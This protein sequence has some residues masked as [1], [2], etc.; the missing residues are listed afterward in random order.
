M[1]LDDAMAL[2]EVDDSAL[3]APRYSAEESNM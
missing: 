3:N 1:A 2:S